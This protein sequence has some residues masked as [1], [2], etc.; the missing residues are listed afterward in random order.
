MIASKPVVMVLAGADPTGGAGIGADI[1]A[2][3]AQGCHAAP[4]ITTVTVQ[5][6][7]KLLRY[8]P[9]DTELI[10]DQARTVLKDMPVAAIKL[11]MLGSASIIEAVSALLRDHPTLPVVLD[12]V[13]AAGG[14]G[15]LASADMIDALKVLLLPLTTVLVP[16]GPE[17]RRLTGADTLDACAM[18]LLKMG[19]Q[20]VLITGGH[21]DTAEVSNVLYGHQRRL[22]RDAWPRLPYHYHGSGCTLAAALSGLL[23][24][25]QAVANAAREAGRFTW[26]SLEHALPLGTDQHIPDR[27][28]WVG[29]GRR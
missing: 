14:G 8:V 11:G 20:Y 13:L 10:I 24:Q 6:T 21:E 15:A 19:V 5:N 16:N 25:G 9:Q 12:P 7:T 22:A 4:I 23:A 26:H 3:G 29:A 17:A 27:L 1:L 18:A 2:L 28:Y